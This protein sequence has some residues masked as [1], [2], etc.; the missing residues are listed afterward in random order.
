MFKIIPVL[1]CKNTMNWGIG[2]NGGKL[3][4]FEQL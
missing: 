2:N 3:I 4:S 1:Y